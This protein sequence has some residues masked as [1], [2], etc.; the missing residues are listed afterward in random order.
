[1]ITITNSA[2]I[3]LNADEASCLLEASK[4]IKDFCQEVERLDNPTTTI[5]LL[6]ANIGVDGAVLVELADILADQFKNALNACE[7]DSP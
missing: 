7:I 3:V 4:V 6:S 5:Y 1:M 2:T